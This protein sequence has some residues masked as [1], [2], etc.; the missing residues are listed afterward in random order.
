MRQGRHLPI[1]TDGGLQP[2]RT[3]LAWRRTMMSLI[4]AAAIFLRWMPHH[5][6]FASTLVLAAIATAFAINLTLTKRFRRAVHGINRGSM[7]PNALSAAIVAAAV[8][9]L[10]ILGICTV[11]FFH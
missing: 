3:G 5:G 4:V 7:E 8:S 2:E 9:I 1:H 10:A 6:W 11:L